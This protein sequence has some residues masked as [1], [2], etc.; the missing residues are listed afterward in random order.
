MQKNSAG[1]QT[2]DYLQIPFLYIGCVETIR[3]TIPSKSLLGKC[4][5]AEKSCVSLSNGEKGG[6]I[7]RLAFHFTAR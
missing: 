5:S 4:C 6:E 3:V 2:F 1:V 7:G